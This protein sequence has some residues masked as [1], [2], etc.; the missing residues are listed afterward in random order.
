MRRCPRCGITNFIET[1]SGGEVCAQCQRKEKNK[2]HQLEYKLTPESPV[3]TSLKGYIDCSYAKLIYLFGDPNGPVDHKQSNY[4]WVMRDRQGDMVVIYDWCGTNNWEPNLPS[5]TQFKLLPS[6]GWHI[7][8]YTASGSDRLV[9][10]IQNAPEQP[11]PKPKPSR[12][13]VEEPKKIRAIE[14]EE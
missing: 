3:G 6:H 1:F 13:K 9:H 7:G 10:F 2:P 5:L 8:A 12:F 14:L 11:T 4:R